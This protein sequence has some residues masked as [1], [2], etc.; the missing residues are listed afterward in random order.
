MLWFGA[1]SWGP[2]PP[3]R[4]SRSARPSRRSSTALRDWPEHLRLGVAAESVLLGTW[5]AVLRARPAAGRRPGRPPGSSTGEARSHRPGPLLRAGH[6]VPGHH[7]RARHARRGGGLMGDLTTESPGHRVRRRRGGDRRR[8]GRGRADGHRRRGGPLGRP[9]RARA[10]LA[11]RDGGQVP[12]PGRGR[13]AGEP[14]DRLRRGALRR[15]QHRD[16]QRPLPPPARAPGAGVAH[17]LRHRRVHPEVLEAYA[18]R[19]SPAV[20]GP[21]AWRAAVVR[22]PER[23]HQARL[24]QRRVRPVFSYDEAG[25]APSRRCRTMLPGPPGDIIPDCRWSPGQAG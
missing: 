20:G 6:E 21:P 4:T 12:A 18:E 25:A 19:S 1:R 5:A 22:R 14:P 16:Q 10:V 13:R 11:G 9:R 8:A 3:R 15:R 17:D 7:G 23:G 2:S 24:A